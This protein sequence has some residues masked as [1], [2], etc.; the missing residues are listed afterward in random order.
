M[1]QLDDILAKLLALRKLPYG[2]RCAIT[3]DDIFLLCRLV[4]PLFRKQPCLLELKANL[5]IVGDIHGQFYDLLRIFEKVGYPPEKNYLFLGDYVDRGS[6]SLEV[7][8][9]LMLFKIKYPEN[10]FLLRGNHESREMNKVYGFY[11]ECVKKFNVAIWNS[12]VDVFD[13]MPFAAIIQDKIF[14]VHGG[15]SPIL[16]NVAQINEIERP[17]EIPSF[18]LI[19]DI[20]WSDPVENV[21]LWS[22]S[23][24]QIGFGFGKKAVENFCQKTQIEVIV[25][26]HQV[27]MDGFSM[28]IPGCESC[29]A[30]FSAPNYVGEYRNRGAVL[31][32][33]Q[34]LVCSFIVF[35]PLDWA[36]QLK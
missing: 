25:R 18:G 14:C 21:E 10:F 23:E 1:S 36:Q 3:A 19:S 26:S 32:V 20:V 4:K 22:N 9:L 24:R 35:N 7:F 11:A 12:I 13:Y 15:I 5:A 2:T 28:P 31:I 8:C 27:Q 6:N 29:I 30:V 17:T 34:D 33:D 16:N